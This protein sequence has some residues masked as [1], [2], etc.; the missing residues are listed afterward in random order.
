MHCRAFR[1]LAGALFTLLCV[2]L[3]SLRY[4][5]SVSLRVAQDTLR[6][7]QPNPGSLELQLADIFIAVKTTWAF[8]RARLDLL[9]D[10]WVSRTRQQTFIFTDSPDGNLQERLGSHLVVTNCSAEHSH[11]ALSCKMAAEFDAFLA[12]GLRWFCHV[13]DDN[14]VNPRALLQLLRTFPQD[15]DVYVGKP[16]L[17][18]PIHASELQSKNRTKL[19]QFWFATGGA[20]FCISRQLALKM[21][22]WARN[23]G[24]RTLMVLDGQE[25]FPGH[26]LMPLKAYC[27]LW[28]VLPSS[29]ALQTTCFPLTRPQPQFPRLCQAGNA[30]FSCL[31]SH[32]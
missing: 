3:L 13:D 16:S 32:C 7:S 29:P 18:R 15:R 19:V 31:G 12:S 14:Y 20:G 5:S 27:C 23:P 24:E 28:E 22:P 8:H 11:P 2:G 17:N 21:V 30:P 10:T 1:S 25:M 6:L 4:H 9:L 26:W